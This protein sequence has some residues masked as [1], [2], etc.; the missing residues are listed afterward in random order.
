[1]INKCEKLLFVAFATFVI[2]AFLPL[3]ASAQ[4]RT[5]LDVQQQQVSSL[6]KYLTHVNVTLAGWQTSGWNA[7]GTF[8]NPQ[9][10]APTTNHILFI[11][12]DPR[13]YEAISAPSAVVDGVVICGIDTGHTIYGNGSASGAGTYAFDEN[14]GAVIWYDAGISGS[15]WVFDNSH[16]LLGTTMVN[17]S[18]GQILYTVPRALGTYTP[19]LKIG[20][21]SGPAGPLGTGTIAAYS[22]ANVSN[23]KL[24]W[25][26]QA[27]E[28]TAATTYANGRV[29]F[30]G[31]NQY[32]IDCLNATTGTVLW[33]QN[34]PDF[35]TSL[36]SGYGKLY[37]EG[38]TGA[39]CLDQVT[40]KILWKS[41]HNG[42]EACGYCLA[43]GLYYEG[44]SNIGVFAL[45]ATTGAVVWEYQ[46][47]RASTDVFP[48]GGSNESNSAIPWGPTLSAGGGELFF[49]DL[50]HTAYGIMLP[51]NWKSADGLMFNPHPWAVIAQCGTGEFS[52]LNA[53][54]GSLIWKCGVAE[55]GAPGP[56]FG[57]GGE[58]MNAIEADGNVYALNTVYSGHVSFGDTYSAFVQPEQFMNYEWFP[59]ALW[60]YGK[61]PTQL[62]G[63]TVSSSSIASGNSVTVSGI[64]N[65]LSSPISSVSICSKYSRPAYSPATSVPIILSYVTANGGTYLATVNT[66][67]NG[68][69]SYTFYPTAT[70]SVVIQS[71]G[72]ASYY[73]PDTA[74]APTVQVTASSSVT[75]LIGFAAFATIVAIA[76]PVIVYR[77]EPEP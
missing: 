71:P 35:I 18:N 75:T 52:A 50:Q 32:E 57:A 48:A 11:A 36:T 39:V 44:E 70:G 9:G 45:N 30:G 43:Y 22:F 42:R 67:I 13:P 40:G 72:S 10:S 46:H 73:A 59:P 6:T 27:Y 26:S 23:P 53:Y 29:F 38:W 7:S 74:Y 49:P 8:A 28:N 2:V 66:D 5:N 77:R 62:N 63:I 55:V 15:A 3:N 4:T 64:L 25:T 14:T 54:Y 21:T 33:T 69:F 12:K 61:G 65:D 24:L 34:V 41:P 47:Q 17:P 37:A 19:D 51:P 68:K 31:R 20:F 56:S 16:M 60:C 58:G 1:M 76:V